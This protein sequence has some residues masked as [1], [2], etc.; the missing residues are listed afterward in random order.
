MTATPTTAARAAPEKGKRPASRALSTTDADLG[1][2]SYNGTEPTANE[3][4]S[5]QDGGGWFRVIRS[6]QTKELL[7]HSR[8]F[9]LHALIAVRARWNIDGLNTDGLEVGE[10]LIG[11]FKEAGLRTRGQYRAALELLIQRGLVTTTRTNRGTIAK[12]VSRTVFDIAP[13]DKRRPKRAQNTPKKQPS[14][15]PS[16]QPSEQPS[17]QPSVS[18]GKARVRQPS[19]QPSDR[20]LTAI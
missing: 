16:L 3:Q 9:A 12:L 4:P 17:E 20:H 15:Q 6:P 2:K 1:T 11:D 18:R 19:A 5:R 8:A 14:L 7:R 10:A 13:P